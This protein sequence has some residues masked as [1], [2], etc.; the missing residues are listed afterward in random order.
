VERAGYDVA[1]VDA[2]TGPAATPVEDD[3]EERY[4]AQAWGRLV[5]AAIPA[6]LIMLLMIPHMVWQPIPGYLAIVAVLAFPVVFPRGGRATH[7]SAWRA[8]TARRTWT[9]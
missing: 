4:L 7:R 3:V 2:G 8:L 1:R 6:T 9:C 5:F